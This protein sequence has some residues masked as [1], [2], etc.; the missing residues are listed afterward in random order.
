MCKIF[1][2]KNWIFVLFYDHFVE[3]LV[4]VWMWLRVLAHT[5][6]R[7]RAKMK[8]SGVHRSLQMKPS[9]VPK[10]KPLKER[11]N[12]FPSTVIRHPKKTTPSPCHHYHQQHRQQQQQKLQRQHWWWHKKIEGTT[13]KKDT[14]PTH[15]HTNIYI[16]H[17][18]AIEEKDKVAASRSY[19]CIQIPLAHTHT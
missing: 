6:D 7:K 19:S 16:K 11:K 8:E 5:R 9:D 3:N 12:G 1:L 17:E 2:N 15:P 10:R 4:W 13:A 18:K 14:P